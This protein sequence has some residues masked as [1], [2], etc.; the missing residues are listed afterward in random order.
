MKKSL[1]IALFAVAVGFPVAGCSPA[2]ATEM[3]NCQACNKE[4]PK[5][6]L[7]DHGGK[8][9]CKDCDNH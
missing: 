2:A 9:V 7:H 8:L 5:A 6:D 4:F 3:A 1:L